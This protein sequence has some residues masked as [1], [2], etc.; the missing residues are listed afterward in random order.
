MLSAILYSSITAVLNG[1]ELVNAQKQVTL[2]AEHIFSQLSTDLVA[3]ESIAL[4]QEKKAGATSAQAPTPNPTGGF[5]GFAV[6]KFLESKNQK[7][8]NANADSI[9]FATHSFPITVVSEVR[10][11]GIVE[12]FYHLEELPLF[13]IGELKH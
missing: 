13:A 9:R 1:R 2:T 8:Q 11:F 5:A 4:E 12:V 7:K 3:R 6:R 10:T